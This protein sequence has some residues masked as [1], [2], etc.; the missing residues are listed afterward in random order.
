MLHVVQDA[1]HFYMEHFLVHV[2]HILG[3]FSTVM[4]TVTFGHFRSSSAGIT[5]PA[6]GARTRQL[7][8]DLSAGSAY[9]E[10]SGGDK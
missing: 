5:W 1:S 7:Q 2:L 10:Y 3:A 9:P 4:S 6:Q 8:V